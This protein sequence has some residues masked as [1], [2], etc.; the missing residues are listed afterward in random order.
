[1]EGARNRRSKK[2]TAKFIEVTQGDKENV[3]RARLAALEKD[4]NFQQDKAA[5]SDE[6]FHLEDSEEGAQIQFQTPEYRFTFKLIFHASPSNQVSD[7][8][9]CDTSFLVPGI[10]YNMKE[11]THIL[12]EI[13]F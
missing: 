3:L 12:S 11:S 9:S 2:N 1:M 4:D 5:G 6:E 8:Y 10:H 13:W 7:L